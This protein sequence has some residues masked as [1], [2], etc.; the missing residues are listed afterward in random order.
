MKA[1]MMHSKGTNRPAK[2][3]KRNLYFVEKWANE[4]HVHM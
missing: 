2:A 1:K 3:N 4:G